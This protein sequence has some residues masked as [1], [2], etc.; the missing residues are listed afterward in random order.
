V[1][2]HI[3]GTRWN[4]YVFFSRALRESAGSAQI[5]GFDHKSGRGR[6][7]IGVHG[8]VNADEATNPRGGTD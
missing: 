8:N 6:D 2:E 5:S 7:L 4:G 3:T 1:A